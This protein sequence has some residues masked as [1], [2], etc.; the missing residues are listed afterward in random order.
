MVLR[1]TMLRAKLLVA[2]LCDPSSV[3]VRPPTGSAHITPNG[4]KEDLAALSPC[5]YL[6]PALPHLFAAGIHDLTETANVPLHAHIRVFAGRN[7][8][9][10]TAQRAVGRNAVQVCMCSRTVRV[11]VL[12]TK[13]RR[14]WTVGTFERKEVE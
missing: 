13:G 3:S 1:E 4:S 14:A 11:E 8:N 9:R 2:F 12:R 5:T 10:I 6:A 7:G